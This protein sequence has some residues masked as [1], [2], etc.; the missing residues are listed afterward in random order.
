MAAD[1]RQ[2]SLDH[3]YVFSSL[4]LESEINFHP[5]IQTPRTPTSSP[6]AGKI[7]IDDK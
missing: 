4:S 1:N 7:W 3:C 6:S 5:G 2:S